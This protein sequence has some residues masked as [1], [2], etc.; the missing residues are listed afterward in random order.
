MIDENCKGVEAFEEKHLIAIMLFLSINGQCRKIEIYRQ[1][2]SNPRIPEKLDR[3]ER[4]GLISQVND[5]ASRSVIVSLTPKGRAVADL[6]LQM[7]KTMKLD[8]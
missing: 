7:D 5:S 3:M 1:V 4:L 2:S 8:S 6:L